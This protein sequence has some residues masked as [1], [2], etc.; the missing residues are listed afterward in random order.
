MNKKIED[1]VKEHIEKA[2]ARGEYADNPLTR[3]FR[4]GNFTTAPDG[5]VAVRV[6]VS[7]L[8]NKKETK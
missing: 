7:G 4:E 6:V 1:V 8:K 3:A 5:T 2:V